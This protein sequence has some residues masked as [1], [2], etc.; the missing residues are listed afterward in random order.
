MINP[1][2]FRQM[3]DINM[4]RSKIHAIYLFMVLC[5][6]ATTTLRAQNVYFV[7]GYHGGIYGHYPVR[8]KTQY[9]VDLLAQYPE[10]N[11]CIEIEPETWD[12]VKA[13]TPDAYLNFRKIAN[14]KRVDFTNPTYAQPYCYNISGESLIRQFEYGIQKIHQH[15]PEVQFHTYSVEEPCFTSSLPQILKQFGI[16]YAVLKCPN[17]CWGGYTQA[18]GGELVNWVGPDGSSILTVPRYACEALEDNSTWQTKAWANSEEYLQA[19]FDYGINH[20]V[21][22]CFQDAGWKNG[23]WLGTGKQIKNN[24]VYVTWTDYFEN[25]SIGK[26]DDDWHFSQ[27]DLLVNLMWG[28]QVLQKIGQEV[29]TAENNVVMAEKIGSI[30]H[31]ANNY[32][33]QQEETDNAWRT[34]LLAQ[35]HD[36]WIVPYNR[37][38]EHRTWAEEIA[39]WTGNTNTISDNII[40]AAFHSFDKNGSDNNKTD[41]NSLTTDEG[42]IRIYNTLGVARNEVVS[43][44]LP[45]R[46]EALPADH[47]ATDSFAVYDIKGKKTPFAIEKEGEKIRLFIKAEVPPFGY[48]TY[49]VTKEKSNQKQ[50][51]GISFTSANECVMENELYRIV[52][53]LSKGGTIKSLVAKKEGHKEFV[54]RKQPFALDELRGHFYEEGKFHSSADAP[55][56]ITVLKD[57]LLEKS[58]KIEGHIATHPFT[59]IVTLSKGQR[60]IDFELNIHWK[61]NVGIGEYKQKGDNWRENRRAFCDDRFKLNILFPTA[62]QS[63][64]IYKNAPF[65]VCES[66]L[67]NTHFDRWS[68]IKHNVIL[69]WIDLAEENNDGHGLALFSDHTTSYSYGEDFPLGL[70][71]QYSG[72]GLWGAD[73][74]ITRPLNIRYALVPHCG[75]WDKAAISAE[76]NAWNEPLLCH[77]HSSVD[78]KSHSFID[79]QN[80]GYEL[81][82]VRILEDGLLVR[83]FNPKGNNTLQ[84]GDDTSQKIV[85][86]FP[87]TSIQ[88]IDLNGNFITEKNLKTK[89]SQNE[90]IVSIP[91]F[92]LKTFL[93]K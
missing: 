65:D 69:H 34:L 81:S 22:M 48:T 25:I 53:D 79:V 72:I 39:L 6:L 51:S 31:L 45:D 88:E 60:R 44:L 23:P 32:R 58:L 62:L 77:Y 71:V 74:K 56:V 42:Y 86:N 57:N 4:N 83:V 17:T 84:K 80:S 47:R 19:C 55:A 13:R 26:T 29:R 50:T 30:A 49:R 27:E 64:K 92:G 63:P 28:S 38:N 35:H 46:H 24:S 41:K 3:Y 8:W 14:D 87:V 78:M 73:Y 68:N 82:A 10:W 40:R 20:P 11:M 59:R 75:K 76:N 70:T 91:R 7:D 54:D 66:H 37:L 33:Y 5:S 90:I 52:F 93:V 61:Q 21:G 1:F 36:S 43:L 16:K 15:F 2:A 9:M 12:T 67:D 85:F 18:Y 89:S